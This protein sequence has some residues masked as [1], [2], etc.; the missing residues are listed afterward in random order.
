MNSA[1]RPYCYDPASDGV[2]TRYRDQFAGFARWAAE[3]FN[4]RM[5]IVA[6]RLNLYEATCGAAA[7]TSLVDFAGEAARRIAASEALGE[8]PITIASV[9]VEDLYGLPK[10]DGRCQTGTAADCLAGRKALLAQLE[11]TDVMVTG[12]E[13]YPANAFA[14]LAQLLPGDWL[15]R[16][17]AVTTKPSVI[18]GAEVP[19]MPL[20]TERRRVHSLFAST[21][22]QQRA[23]LDQVRPRGRGA[24]R[25][26]ARRT[27][28]HLTDLQPSAVV[29]SCPC[30]GDFA[31]CS[32]LSGLGSK[33]DERRLRLVGGLVSGATERQAFAVWKAL[34]GP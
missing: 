9:D 4:P 29:S 27:W 14:D 24:A 16:V 18:A 26:G 34:L 7:Y 15:S 31:L 22:A 2:P 13:S 17:L 25:D 10:K 5:V 1:W 21:E 11:A 12:L 33:R 30:A 8:K 3:R 19:A 23:F 28:R 20:S 6:Q 32:H